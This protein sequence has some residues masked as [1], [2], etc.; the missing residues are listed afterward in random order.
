MVHRTLA[1]FYLFTKKDYPRAIELAET[2]VRLEPTAMNYLVLGR[3]HQLNGDH[4]AALSAIERAAE[5]EPENERLQG[6]YQRI[7]EEQ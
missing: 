7:K 6:T 1:Q 3:A 4:S 5:L 2:A